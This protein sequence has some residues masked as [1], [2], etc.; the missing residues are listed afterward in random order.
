MKK[1]KIAIAGF[2]IVGKRRYE[3]LSKNKNI[4]IVAICDR[5]TE[6]CLMDRKDISVYS[7]YIDLLDSESIDAI[8]ISLTNDIAP[9]ATIDSLK[10]N[11]HVFCEK[12][13]GRSV[14]DIRDVIEVEK[15][16]KHNGIVLMYGFNHRYHDSILDAL[17]LVNSKKL[18]DIINLR[19]VYGKS[20]MVTFNQS[21]WRTKRAI[22]GGGVLLDQG[23]H[24]VDLMRLFAGK[25]VQVHSFVSNG[26]W[27]YDVED[28][29]YALMKTDN[30]IVGLLHSSATEWRHRFSLDITLEKGAI[31]LEGLLSGSKS[32]GNETMTV[33]ESKPDT[34]AGN[35][36]SVTTLYNSDPSWKR[37]IDKF[38]DLINDK[39]LDKSILNSCNSIEALRTM[40]LVFK[41]YESDSDWTY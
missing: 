19:G 25:F 5:D 33:V 31:K 30:G 27:G 11:I 38:I 36:N 28:N 14:S 40:E 7:N 15:T 39:T 37:E 17:S 9:Q 21:D 2:G 34:D 1:I 16:Q 6:K 4:E 41:I 3:I 13:P 32:Y 29:A 35:P 23:I 20:M 8:F 18:G 12:P 26:F 10:R 22:A 24:M